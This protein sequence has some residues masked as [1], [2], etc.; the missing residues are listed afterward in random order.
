MQFSNDKASGSYPEGGHGKGGVN[1][2]TNNLSEIMPDNAA[3][4][5]DRNQN[6]LILSDILSINVAT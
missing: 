1:T 6:Q 2:T 3:L 4:S 5:D